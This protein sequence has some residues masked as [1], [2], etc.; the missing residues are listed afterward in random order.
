MNEP[1]VPVDTAWH[2]VAGLP[3]TAFDHGSIVESG[4]IATPGSIHVV[5]GSVTVT[6]ATAETGLPSWSFHC[7]VVAIRKLALAVL[8]WV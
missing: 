6:P 7:S 4:S 8:F 3:P 1:Q 2:P 5:D